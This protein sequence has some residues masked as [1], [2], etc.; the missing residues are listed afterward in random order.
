M[1]STKLAQVARVHFEHRLWKNELEAAQQETT[2][3]MNIL[4][5]L[6]TRTIHDTHNSLLVA[7]FFK[8]FQHF[9][10]LMKRLLEE[11]HS[12]EKEIADSYS[13]GVFYDKE[14]KKDHQYLSEDF[15]FDYR[16]NKSAFK[17]FVSE[18]EKQAN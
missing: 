14:Q 3:F 5:E 1:T 16:E 8:Q 17:K 13:N 2:F 4:S 7:S 9:E 6:K 15:E 18:Y 12:I 10:R 11:I